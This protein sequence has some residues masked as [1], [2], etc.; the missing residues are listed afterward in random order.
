MDKN[1]AW[2]W[3]VTKLKK[4]KKQETEGLILAVQEQAI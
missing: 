4:R 3:L 1:K 2:Q